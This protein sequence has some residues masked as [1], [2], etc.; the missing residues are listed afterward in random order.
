MRR[1]LGPG[2]A[3]VLALRAGVVSAEPGA[4][5]VSPLHGQR[6]DAR[7]LAAERAGLEREAARPAGPA[8]GRTAAGPDD[9]G[10]D[11]P[12]EV[13]TDPRLVLTS[14]LLLGAGATSALASFVVR[15]SGTP[16]AG[17]DQD[18]SD[19]L[20]NGLLVTG[21]ILGVAG[22]VFLVSSRSRVRVTPAITASSAG[23]SISGEL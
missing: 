21:A 9:A 11:A 10:Q 19:D 12:T 14:V 16:Q 23:L 6:E 15:P 4:P 3:I 22:L 13:V 1:V 8:P 17:G 20:S 5:Q 18:T 7:L 2:L